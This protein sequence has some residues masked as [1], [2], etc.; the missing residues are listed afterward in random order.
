MDG[1][2]G[3]DP[4][5]TSRLRS[6]EVVLGNVT[7]SVRLKPLGKG[8][9]AAWEARRTSARLVMEAVSLASPSPRPVSWAGAFVPRSTSRV[10]WRS[11]MEA[12]LRAWYERLPKGKAKGK[13]IMGWLGKDGR[14]N[15]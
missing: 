9:V 4:F 8:W 11:S 12:H 10:S 2:A 15:G 3:A 7:R 6:C 1:V 5:M 13:V 14:E